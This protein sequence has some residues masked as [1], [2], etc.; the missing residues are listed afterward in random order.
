MTKKL[1]IIL[2]IVA[3]TGCGILAYQ[4]L[5]LII[6]N[7]TRPI[8]EEE[9]DYKWEDISDQYLY[10]SKSYPETKK[11]VKEIVIDKSTKTPFVIEYDGKKETIEKIEFGRDI[12]TSRG[13]E[14]PW[15]C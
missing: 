5:G 9:L 10:F 4:Y 15:T 11:I 8:L 13:K 2:I 7:F 1:L 14:I 3:L 12:W 6:K